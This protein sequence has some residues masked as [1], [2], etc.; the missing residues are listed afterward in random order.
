[1]LSPRRPAPAAGW[2]SPCGTEGEAYHALAEK[3]TSSC[4]AWAAARPWASCSASTGCPRLPSTELPAPDGPPKK[5]RLLGED[6]VAFRDTQGA[7][8]ADRRQLP[9]PRRLALLRPQ[10]GVRAALRLPRLEVRRHRPLRGHAQRAGREHLQGQGARAR[11]SLPRRQR[12]RLDVHGP[13]RRRR[14]RSRAFEINTLPPEQVY[15]PLMMLEECNWV[16]A[17]EGDIDSVAHRL[18]AR[19]SSAPTARSAAPST[20]TSSPRLELLPTDYGACYSARR[21]WDVDGPLLAPHHPVHHAVLLDDRGQRSRHRLGARLGAAGRRSQSPD[22]D[23][24]AAS[25]GR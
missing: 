24:R 22:R 3:T 8:R 13:A 16:Q 18:R 14:R 6:L 25:T 10:R 9:A 11:L 20:G 7:R 4:A 2:P 23:A 17:L 1:M 15:P 12:R 5:V 19:A 21:R